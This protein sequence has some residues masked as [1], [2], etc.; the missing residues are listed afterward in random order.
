MSLCVTFMFCGVICHHVLLHWMVGLNSRV[1]K[2]RIC[3]MRSRRSLLERSTLFLVS[4]A[5]SSA[6]LALSFA[7]SA[8]DLASAT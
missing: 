1:R 8:F 3:L 6:A 4:L 2:S 7:S 5:F